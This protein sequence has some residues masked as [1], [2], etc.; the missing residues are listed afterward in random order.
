MALNKEFPEG[1]GK[2]KNGQQYACIVDLNNKYSSS[3]TGDNVLPVIF[4]L[5]QCFFEMKMSCRES[6]DSYVCIPYRYGV[7]RTDYVTKLQTLST[8]SDI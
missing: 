5:G 4:V 3:L 8:D 6:S 2:C 7:C 1:C